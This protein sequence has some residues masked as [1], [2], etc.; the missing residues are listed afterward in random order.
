VHGAGGC[1]LQ[2]STT[3]V[4]KSIIWPIAGCDRLPPHK[5]SELQMQQTTH[6][7]RKND[8]ANAWLVELAIL[9][10]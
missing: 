4:F 3:Q 7:R 10:L 8:S 1:D 5:S 9:Y 6:T 2:H